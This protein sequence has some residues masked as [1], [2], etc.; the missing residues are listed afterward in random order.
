VG[1]VDRKIVKSSLF[2]EDALEKNLG[3]C[4]ASTPELDQTDVTIQSV[5]DVSG[6]ASQNGCLRFFGVLDSP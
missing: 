1:N 5:S 6:V 4:R 2:F 3:L